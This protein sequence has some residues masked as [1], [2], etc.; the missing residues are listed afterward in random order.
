MTP[1]VLRD[2]DICWADK[3]DNKPICVGCELT[4]EQ[5]GLPAPDPWPRRLP[6]VW[7]RPPRTR[8]R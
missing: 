7:P 5:L 3:F 6:V 2:G 8:K 1:C 4:P